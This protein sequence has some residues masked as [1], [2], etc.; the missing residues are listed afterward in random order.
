MSTSCVN[1]L[2]RVPLNNMSTG[3]AC[4][5]PVVCRCIPGK[6]GTRCIDV[7]GLRIAT[8]PVA[9]GGRALFLLLTAA[10]VGVTKELFPVDTILEVG[11]DDR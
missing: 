10:G 4:G 9:L 3:D 6:D 1:E 5:C 11:V 8:V 7:E 2:N